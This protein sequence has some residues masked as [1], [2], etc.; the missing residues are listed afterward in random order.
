MSS[1]R[2]RE[3]IFME[4]QT[5]SPFR[6]GLIQFRTFHSV[7][8][9]L[10]LMLF[11]SNSVKYAFPKL[12]PRCCILRPFHCPSICRPV[13]V[14]LMRRTRYTTPHYA[15]LSIVSLFL[16]LWSSTTILYT[17]H[18]YCSLSVTQN[19]HTLTNNR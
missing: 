10:I 1:S 3:L 13:Q 8:S 7:S 4:L 15:V 6:A 18:L 16:P 11:S 2:A 17:L 5:N 19:F 14:Y 9:R 12:P